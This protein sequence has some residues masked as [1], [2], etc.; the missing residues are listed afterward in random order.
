MK[1]RRCSGVMASD[2]AN[3]SRAAITLARSRSAGTMDFFTSQPEA[4]AHR[5]PDGGPAHRDPVRLGQ[6][7][8]EL[9]QRAVRPLL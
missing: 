8:D 5:S 2:S 3:R 6:G 4:L 1:T 9:R 7:S